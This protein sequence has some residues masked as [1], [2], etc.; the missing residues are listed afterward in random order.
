MLV[1]PLPGIELLIGSPA[2]QSAPPGARRPSAEYE[3]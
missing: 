2:V 1:E 3:A